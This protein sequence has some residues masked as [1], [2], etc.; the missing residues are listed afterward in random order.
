M[1][2]TTALDLLERTII[3]LER[4]AA[5]DRRRA[6]ELAAVKTELRSLAEALS[7]ANEHRAAL[8]ERGTGAVPILERAAEMADLLT[9]VRAALTRLEMRSDPPAARVRETWWIE[10][11]RF[12][13][14]ETATKIVAAIGWAVAAALGAATMIA[15]S[16]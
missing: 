13:R 8:L 6:D 10:F 3:A 5:S 12:A 2:Q 15:P 11:W 1:S 16:P 4:A 14:S 7:I 9:S